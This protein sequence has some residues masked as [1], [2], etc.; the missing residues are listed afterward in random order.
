M[1]ELASFSLSLMFFLAAMFPLFSSPIGLGGILI[2]ISFCLVCLVALMGSGWYGYILF[3]VYIGGLLVLFIY[4][5]MVSSNYPLAIYPQQA[6]SL[7]VLGL[8][9]SFLI[10]GPAPVR[11]LGWSAWES[12]SQLSLALYIGLVVLLLVVFLA[13]VRVI[14]GGGAL[15]IETAK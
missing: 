5:C 14:T 6:I 7:L 4:V 12:G 1:F 8:M 3:L 2:L 11:F 10:S 13:I 15:S 9:A